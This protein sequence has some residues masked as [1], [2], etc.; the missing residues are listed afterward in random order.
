M[1]NYLKT[2]LTISAF[3]YLALI[4]ILLLAS[5]VPATTSEIQP[6]AREI[7]ERSDKLRNP[8]TPFAT[9]VSLTEYN[10]G[11]KV[12]SLVLKVHSKKQK[13]NGQYRSLVQFLKPQRDAGKLMLQNGNEI[14][15][16][17]P[18][19]KNSIRL[20]AQ[21]RLMGQASNGDVMTSNFALDY[22]VKL[23]GKEIIKDAKKKPQSTYHLHMIAKTDAVTY[24]S[25]DYWVEKL[26][27]RPVKAKFYSSSERL[28]KIVYY[29]NF[30]N[31]LGAIRPTQVLIL[32]GVDTNK[33]TR[34]QMNNYHAIT[35]P[36]A[37]F[38][39][40]FLPRFK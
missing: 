14:W 37:W 5:V 26:S 27:S 16:Y 15:F 20:S 30:Q 12:D 36:E 35:I 21:Q 3:I 7:L 6:S 29:T 8:D 34:M 38:Q 4:N 17:D 2:S 13:N 39:R 28:M 33:V 24:A 1:K 19:A 22:E 25:A 40:S 23:V 11:K 9:K 31:Q 32:D 10:K 18:S